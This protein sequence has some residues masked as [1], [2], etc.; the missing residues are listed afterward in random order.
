MTEA[1]VAE[2][3]GMYGGRHGSGAPPR[4][5]EFEPPDGIFLLAQLDG[6]SVGCGGLARFDAS[7]A[8]IRRMYVVPEAR[9][10]R[11]ARAVLDAL[12]DR[13]RG[14]GYARVRLETGFAQQAAIRL[15]EQAGFTPIPCWG[16]YATDERS[17]CL[18]LEL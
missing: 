12:L 8:E 9:G 4:A 16:P 18:E 2:M 13:A 17:I 3:A 6:E 7:T 5:A 1:S 10:R 14:A 15:Y 11:I